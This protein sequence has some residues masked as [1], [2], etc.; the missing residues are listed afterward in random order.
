M[1][2]ASDLAQAGPGLFVWQAYDNAVKADVFSTAILTKVGAFI[3][4]PIQLDTASLAQLSS[5]GEV[6]GV[7]ATNANHLRAAA[8]YMEAFSVPLF[9]HRESALP[10]LTQTEDGAWIRG[11]LQ[12]IALEGAGPGEIAI[13]HEADGGTL[14]IGD[15][16]INF[17][18]HGFTFLPDKYC[19]DP[20]Q[21]RKSLRKLLPCKAE[22]ML[23]AHGMP[24]LSGAHAR[25]Q[26]LLN[27]DD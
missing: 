25:L 24:I 8:T 3:V 7:I 17:E 16:L 21:M 5:Y 1:V 26:G 18:P 13:Y 6:A 15:A 9:A 14:I 10:H 19:E 23:F 27:A 2:I 12:A 22:R 4:D 20:R 11:E